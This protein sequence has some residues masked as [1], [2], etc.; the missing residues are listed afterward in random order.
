M[1]R[2]GVL[3]GA[4]ALAAC[5]VP[6]DPRIPSDDVVSLSGYLDASADTQWV[7]VERLD[8]T[9]GTS[10]RPLPITVTLVDAASGAEAALVQR[11]WP[12]VVG[13]AHLFWTTAGVAPGRSYRLHVDTEA[14]AATATVVTPDTADYVV[15]VESGP[16]SCPAIVTVSGDVDVAD[17]QAVFRVVRAGRPSDVRI[18]HAARVERAPD[19]T[20]RVSLYYADDADEALAVGQILSSQ[21][22]VSVSATEWPVHPGAS[23]ES[24]LLEP[25]FGAEGQIEGGVGFVGGVV[26][27]WYAYVPPI[28]P[29]SRP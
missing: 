28:E 1:T 9:T 26:S 8:A 16:Q 5:E 14:G 21:I 19:G 13:P 29:C 7:R 6:F 3:L 23:I 20:A 10:G 2:L 12:T 27:E 11:V 17:V 24:V 25:T 4:A 15:S 22:R 18:S